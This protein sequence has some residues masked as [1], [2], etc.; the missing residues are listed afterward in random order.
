MG[1]RIATATTIA[2]VALAGTGCDQSGPSVGPESDPADAELN[3]LLAEPQCARDQPP[4]VPL[5]LIS[6]GT[7]TL[8]FWPYTGENYSGQGQDP[9]NLVFAGHADPRDIRAALLA[10]DG[11]RTALGMPAEPPFSST[12]DDAIG[13]VQVGYGSATGWTG[14]AIQLACGDYA[15]LRFHLRLF[16]IGDWTVGNAHFEMAIPG[17]ADHQ[18]LSWELAE[19][20]VI[21]D[22]MRAGILDPT[23]PM[24]PSGPINEPMFRTIPA[25]VYNLMPV[26][27]RMLIG[28][29]AGDVTDDVPI[30]SDGVA[31][32]LN[33]AGQIPQKPET[34]T[35][36]LIIQFGQ[37]IPKPFCSSG[38]LDYLYVTG[39]VEL[40][41]T[42]TLGE[43]GDFRMRFD[44]QGTLD[45]QPV[46]PLTGQPSGEPLTA[47]VLEHHSARLN[48][49]HAAAS[50]WLFQRLGPRAVDGAGFYFR[51]LH[52]GPYGLNAFQEI[53]RCASEP[54]LLAE[55]NPQRRLVITR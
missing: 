53:E 25:Q 32:I 24:A 38:P 1:R 20:F 30:A 41:Q 5:V 40:R 10:L 27:V 51:R 33:L 16:R 17:T 46:N 29:P 36:N 37:T 6:L 45:A 54:T 47:L 12:W 13:D 11:D 23:A 14:G 49:R 19:Q 55:Q 18:V 43:D 15:P 35:Q 52:A 31:T 3:S 21:G 4:P 8:E 50:S 22:F 9:I 39:A 34:R 28:G 26:E 7:E 42:T 44:A 48:D 2:L